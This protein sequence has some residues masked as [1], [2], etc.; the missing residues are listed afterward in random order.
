MYQKKVA[1]NGFFHTQDFGKAQ[2]RVDD[3]SPDGSE[4]EE[5]FCLKG[6]HDH[7]SLLPLSVISTF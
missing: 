2:K 3:G 6:S 4:E 7:H 1:L 5:L